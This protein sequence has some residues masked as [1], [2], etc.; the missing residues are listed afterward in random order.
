M[1]HAFVNV[2]LTIVAGTAAFLGVR[3]YP[4]PAWGAAQI[5]WLALLAVGL[6]FWTVARFQL[7]ASFTVTAQ[8][9]KLVSTGLYSKIRNPI[10]VFGSCF[11]AGLIL[12]VAR[13]VWLLAFAVIVPLQ[14]WRAGNEAK[15]LEETFGEEYRAYRAGTW[16]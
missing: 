9:R 12:V 8:A 7:G 14:L 15:V 10:Y 11:L 6:T 4:P 16:F 5:L 13:P 3:G 1:K 2:I